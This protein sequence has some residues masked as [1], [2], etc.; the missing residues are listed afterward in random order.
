M[1][2]TSDGKGELPSAGDRVYFNY[3]IKSPDGE[4]LDEQM[5]SDQP[6]SIQ[7]GENENW[8]IWQEAVLNLKVG[9]QATLI[10]PS[11]SLVDFGVETDHDTLNMTLMR[12][13]EPEL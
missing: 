1:E 6:L 4:I 11:E 7:L 8:G 3:E 5:S 10:V 9:S 13:A 2:L 12:V